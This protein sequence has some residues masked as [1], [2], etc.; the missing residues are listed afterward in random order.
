MD[1]RKGEGL[2]QAYGPTLALNI[3]RLGNRDLCP[4]LINILSY[5]YLKKKKKKKKL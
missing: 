1:G 4:H 3:S 2:V 5:Y